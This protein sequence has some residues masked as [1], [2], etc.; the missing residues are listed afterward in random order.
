MSAK[1]RVNYCRAGAGE[2][3]KSLWHMRHDGAALIRLCCRPDTVSAPI[4]QHLS[5]KNWQYSVPEN[6]PALVALPKAWQLVYHRYFYLAFRTACQG[7]HQ[8]VDLLVA[9]LASAGL[10]N[11]V[12]FFYRCL[13]S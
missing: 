8:S 11:P 13:L 7:I 9:A 3:D 2:S 10:N 6:L 1:Y 12:A 4:S 5:R